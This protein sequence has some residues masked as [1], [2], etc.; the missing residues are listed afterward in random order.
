MSENKELSIYEAATMRVCSSC[1]RVI[2]PDDKPV[3]FL[4][5]NCGKIEIL[6]CS[7]CRKQS[8]RY[9]CPVCGFKGP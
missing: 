5:P 1:G 9:T 8:V 3:V 2:P 6:R 7:K 4:C